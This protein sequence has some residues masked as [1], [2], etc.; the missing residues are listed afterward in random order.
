MDRFRQR[1]GSRR[2]VRLH[3]GPR[4]VSARRNRRRRYGHGRE[5]PHRR[6]V[7]RRLDGR[8]RRQRHAHGRSG[9]RHDG[10]RS[11]RRRLG[12]HEQVRPG[13]RSAAQQRHRHGHQPHQL[14][15]CSRC[16]RSWN[17]RPPPGRPAASPS[18]ATEQAP[19]ALLAG[20]P[21]ANVLDGGHGRDILEGGRG[22]DTYY[23]DNRRDLIIENAG[24]GGRTPS[25][26]R[27][28]GSPTT[29]PSSNA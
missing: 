6:V 10:R 14:Q 17:T 4:R 21:G 22:N 25:T 5:R 13:R 29:G 1:L 19:N 28:A 18:R 26:A 23:V 24:G 11:G 3:F 20:N 2:Q 16:P 15:A 27:S 9:R 7:T 8:L 12:R